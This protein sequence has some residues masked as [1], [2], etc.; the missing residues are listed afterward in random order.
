MIGKGNKSRIA[1]GKEH[2][3]YEMKSRGKQVYSPGGL[4][5]G[6]FMGSA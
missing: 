4:S 5:H 2:G 1:K 3:R 6:S